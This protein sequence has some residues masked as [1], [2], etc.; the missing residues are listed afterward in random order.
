MTRLTYW[1]MGVIAVLGL[2]LSILLHEMAHSVVARVFGMEIKGITLWLLGG[3]AELADEPPHPKA[4]FLMAIAGP[5]MSVALAG[6]FLVSGSLT[7]QFVDGAPAVAIFR[8]LGSLNLILAIF[9]LFPAFPLDGGRIMRAALWSWKGDQYW[10]TR[11]AARVGSSFGFGLMALGVFSAF[12]GGGFGGLWW[13][14]LGMFIRFS[15]DAS[16]YQLRARRA[17]EGVAV[18]DFMT[19]EPIS[20]PP[21]ITI[22]RLINDWVYKHSFEFFPVVDEEKLVGCVS[23]MEIKQV[24]MDHRDK[25]TVRDIMIPCSPDNMIEADQAASAALKKMQSSGNSRFMVTRNGVLVG[26]I[27]LKDLLALISIKTELEEA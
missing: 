8:Y 13:I 24:P 7:A 4:E 20:A 26:V 25:V 21:D 3:V 19:R 1:W 16:L 18:S 17:L 15:A 27:A 11:V 10:A 14:L 5:I 12:T 23:L 2:F 22:T 6:L 9:N